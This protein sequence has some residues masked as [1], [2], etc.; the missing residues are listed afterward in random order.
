MCGMPSAS[1][2][3]V[4]QS[5]SPPSC[6]MENL[7]LSTLQDLQFWS[8]YCEP[9][10]YIGGSGASRVQGEG[11]FSYFLP[12]LLMTTP[13]N[14]SARFA[15]HHDLRISMMICNWSLLFL[16]TLTVTQVQLFCL[17]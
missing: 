7:R 13:I 11:G 10:L 15:L 16:H 5:V 2:P 4:V 6:K 8:P 9:V 14:S 17:L 12:F 1:P 3:L